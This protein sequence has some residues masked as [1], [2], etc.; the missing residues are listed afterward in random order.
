MR[1]PFILPL[2]LVACAEPKYQQT[3]SDP[4]EQSEGKPTAYPCHLK[5]KKIDLCIHWQWQI[6][7]T[8]SEVGDFL[9]RTYRLAEQD[10]FPIAVEDFHLE[11]ELW[12]PSMN[13]G[14]S[15]VRVR[16]TDRGLFLAEEVFFVMPG[17]WQIKFQYKENG[18]LIDEAIVDLIF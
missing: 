14:S 2:L 12:M 5:M 1:W 9:F 18:K 17:D 15:P 3:G 4:S 11:I 7:P 6:Y 13:H 8:T 10:A 16:H